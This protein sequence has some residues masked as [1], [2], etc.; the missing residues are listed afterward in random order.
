[1]KTSVALIKTQIAELTNIWRQYVAVESI[2]IN[3]G[4]KSSASDMAAK[5]L[6]VSA[7]IDALEDMLVAAEAAEVVVITKVVETVSSAAAK[8]IEKQESDITYLEIALR[9]AKNALSNIA[10]F[11]GE[12][13]FRNAAI[14]RQTALDA[15]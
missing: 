3:A 2:F 6:A 12:D 11:L 4:N 5:K 9:N 7:E 1:M 10:R 8:K 13:I 15:L 14:A